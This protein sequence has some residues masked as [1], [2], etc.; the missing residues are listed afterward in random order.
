MHN[1]QYASA[2]ILI[3]CF[4]FM[5]EKTGNLQ[6]PSNCL[7]TLEVFFAVYSVLRSLLWTE[8]LLSSKSDCGSSMEI[9]SSVKEF[10][11]RSGN[12]QYSKLPGRNG[13]GFCPSLP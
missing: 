5:V 13:L 4:A 1:L 3:I 11:Y 7:P 6:F 9:F 12:S 2:V 10:C 8:Q